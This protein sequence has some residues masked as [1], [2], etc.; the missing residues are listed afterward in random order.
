MHGFMVSK[1]VG[2]QMSRATNKISRTLLSKP[3]LYSMVSTIVI[4]AVLI[5]YLLTGS[6]SILSPDR[7]GFT[8]FRK[9]RYQEA[10][11]HFTDPLWIGASLF[12]AGS[13]DRA[14]TIYAGYDTSVSAFNQGTCLIMMGKYEDAA[15]RLTRALEI[16]PGWPEAET[17]LALARARAEMLK[18]EG[19]DMT[20]GQLGADEIVFTKTKSS[21]DDAV[22]ETVDGQ[23]L[24]DAEMRA[25]WLRNVQ[26]KPAD[27]L[28]AK[29]AYQHAVKDSSTQSR[30][31]KGPAD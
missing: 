24:S 28:R 17:N 26:T 8:L 1:G 5:C 15:S 13:F 18:K 16:N 12:K 19:G 2:Y 29:F 11:V 14:A 4:A 20:G 30:K 6:L 7:Q 3:V 23:K 31:Q 25:I 10:S 27:F 21:N 22:E 9:Q